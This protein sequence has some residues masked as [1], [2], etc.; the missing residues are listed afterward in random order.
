MAEV[1]YILTG[2]ASSR[3]GR[4]KALL[5]FRG[6][7]LVEWIAA[8]ARLAGLEPCLVGAP[9]RY[10]HLSIPCLDELHAG[11]GPLSGIEAAL[12]HAAPGWALILACDL[13]ALTPDLLRSLLEAGQ[14]STA[15]VAAATAPGRRPEPL[16]AAW[17]TRALPAV[18]QA[19]ARGQRK[20]QD[21]F[22]ELQVL[23][24]PIDS[25]SLTRN[26]NAPED[27][28]ACLP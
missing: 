6:A 15:D 26:V 23:H 17:H 14:G 9:S 28:A 21:L 16:C 12:R 19:L 13:P 8:Q 1:A 4:D 22:S 18:Q 10:A 25:E 20:V 24:H 7:T 2:G 27:F 3:M 11:Q 5:P